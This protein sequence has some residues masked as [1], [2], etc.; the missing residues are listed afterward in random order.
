LDFLP[1]SRG[2]LTRAGVAVYTAPGMNSAA[3]DLSADRMSPLLTTQRLG[4]PYLYF[5]RIGSTNDE[6]HRHAESGAPEGLLVV[7][8]EQTAGRGRLDRAWY[9]PP[10]SS[11]LMSLLLRPALPI[12]RAGQLTMCLGLG[13]VEGVAEVTGLAPRLKWPNDLALNGRKLGGM[14]SEIQ[15]SGDRL[16]FAILGLGL[17]V[18]L[19]FEDGPAAARELASAAI[20]LSDALG[21]Q[22]DRGSLL[23][24]ILRRCGAWYDRLLAD[25]AG[26][27][28][29]Q[30][31]WAQALETLG[32]EVVVTTAAAV[33]RGF[34]VDVAL[35]G[36]L[37]LEDT[38]G[39]RRTLW[40]GDVTS[41]RRVL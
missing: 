7:A 12:E 23:A 37:V 31:A 40:S 14:L 19:S 35:E 2:T 28:S 25:R 13:A 21:R 6:A 5:D 4:R 24:A 32:Q 34:A 22:V 41:T 15:A 18:N 3:Q 30:Q 8:D 29:V 10:G 20:S 38:T 33:H 1:V 9:A 27:A 11:L 26:G 17:N 36:G 39:Q 16:E